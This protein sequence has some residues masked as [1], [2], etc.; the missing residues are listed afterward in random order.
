M[1]AYIRWA[2]DQ[3]EY[4]RSV[5]SNAGVERLSQTRNFYALLDNSTGSS[6]PRLPPARR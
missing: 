1:E 6:P 4:L 3:A 2:T 5:L